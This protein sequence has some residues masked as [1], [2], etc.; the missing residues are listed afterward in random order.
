MNKKTIDTARADAAKSVADALGDEYAIIAK[1]RP[2]QVAEQVNQA[3]KEG[4]VLVGSPF[5]TRAAERE[6]AD[7]TAQAVLRPLR[8]LSE[9]IAA[10]LNAALDDVN[11]STTPDP[12]KD[13]AGRAI[14]DKVERDLAFALEKAIGKTS[15]AAIGLPRDAALIFLRGVVAATYGDE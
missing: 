4:W 6:I 1:V 9:R 15:A 5:S 12:R 8:V 14:F 13:E 3:F 11:L 2:S 10:A 7:L